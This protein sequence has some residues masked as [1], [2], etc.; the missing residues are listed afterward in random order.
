[1]TNKTATRNTE[2]VKQIIMFEFNCSENLIFFAQRF[3][4]TQNSRKNDLYIYKNKYRLLFY[5]ER[6]YVKEL[7]KL[8]G[9]ADSTSRLSTDIAITREHAKKIA[10]N[11]A[12]ENLGKAFL[13]MI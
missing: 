8:S 7:L 5:C 13:K 10:E 2:P 4:E 6:K 12:V 3:Y 1:M 11:N 9:L